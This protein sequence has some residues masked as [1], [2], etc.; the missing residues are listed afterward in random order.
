LLFT[1]SAS[2]ILL[3]VSTHWLHGF[4]YGFLAQFHAVAVILTLVYLPF[5][6][7]FHIFQ[8]PAQ[9]SL[10][11]YRREGAAGPQ[12]ACARCGTPFASAL[13]VG[14]L[15]QVQRELAIHYE[16]PGGTHYQ[17]VCPPCRRKNLALVQDAMWQ[18]TRVEEKV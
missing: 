2:G 12:A 18:G 11:F 14:D 8:R 17:D 3:T 7:F 4:Q 15:K 9:L 6:K 16:M 5:G 1:I 10:D 13:H